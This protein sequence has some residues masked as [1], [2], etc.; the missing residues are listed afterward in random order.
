MKKTHIYRSIIGCLDVTWRHLLLVVQGDK[1]RLDIL[2]EQFSFVSLI[3]A[4]NF[5]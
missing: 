1:Q 3:P 5:L 2:W 4:G